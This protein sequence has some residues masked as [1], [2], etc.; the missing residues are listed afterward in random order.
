MSCNQPAQ[1]WGCGQQPANAPCPPQDCCDSPNCFVSWT[2]G[3]RTTGPN[4][5]V[6]LTLHGA[7]ANAT[8]PFFVEPTSGPSYNVNLIADNAGS[9]IAHL[10][11]NSGNG[12]YLF[13]PRFEQCRFSPQ[14]DKV[15]VGVPYNSGCSGVTVQLPPQTPRFTNVKCLC[16]N[17]LL[18][19]WKY[20]GDSGRYKF[21]LNYS[22]DS[23]P[24]TWIIP[25]DVGAHYF[26]E[27]PHGIG[28]IEII[29]TVDDTIIET[30]A[31]DCCNCGS[32]VGSGGQTG[33]CAGALLVLPSFTGSP[34][35]NNGQTATL[36]LTVQNTN[37]APVVTGVITVPIP[38]CLGGGNVTIPAGLTIGANATQQFSFTVTGTNSTAGQIGCEVVVSANMG[39]YT[40]NGSTYAISGGNANIT[41]QGTQQV[42]GIS[43]QA[44]AQ[45]NTIRH[46]QTTT[47]TI[48]ITNTGNTVITGINFPSLTLPAALSG[49]VSFTLASL[50]PGASQSFPFTLTGVNPTGPVGIVAGISIPANHLSGS[51]GGGVV[52]NTSSNVVV[53]VLPPQVTVVGVGVDGV[54]VG[55]VGVGGG[56]DGPADPFWCVNGNCVQSATAP[57]GNTGG[58][59]TTLAQ[60]QSNCQAVPFWCYNNQCVQ[61]ATSPG[62]GATGPYSTLAQCQSSCTNSTAGYYCNGSIGQGCAY[63]P[64]HPNP[65]DPAWQ[66]P[67]PTY[68]ACTSGTGGGNGCQVVGGSVGVDGVGVDG[69][70]VDGVG[71]DGGSD[72]V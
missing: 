28:T 26:D 33:A 13:T 36:V 52:G 72:A 66:G 31:F 70:G 46:G 58:P 29:D 14:C 7:P 25:Q 2:V 64:S 11:L 38:P 35:I 41:I 42:C 21:R 6:T 68:V 60:C 32:G 23:A 17:G 19:N 69:V 40:C 27:L 18:V 30:Y 3:P 1:S 54:G 15:F 12:V 4:P 56:V 9:A 43:L 53:N 10:P 44:V 37:A 20:A 22:D 48:T 39:T 34:I 67:F 5:T 24:D 45:P 55:G 57:T 71:V 65:I 50:A 62:A 59:Y 49:T 63:Y 8:I 16:D 47:L 51:C 61:S